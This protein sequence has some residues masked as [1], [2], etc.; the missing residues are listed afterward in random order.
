MSKIRLQEQAAPSTPA[1][2]KVFI[3]PKAGGEIYKKS[4]DGVEEQFLT[5][6][7][8]Q[9]IPTISLTGGQIAFPATAVP[10]TDPNT[11]DDYEE[12]AWTLGFSFGGGTTGITYS[13]QLG[14]YIKNSGIV[15]CTGAVTLT[16]KG[17]DNGNA[18]ITGL[19][20]TVFD[21]DANYSSAF[22]GYMF[23]IT[24]ADVPMFRVHRNSTIVNLYKT[25]NAGVTTNITDAAFANNS[26]LSGLGFIYLIV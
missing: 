19:P 3:Y 1:A 18:A 14:K 9:I 7:G 17:A 2:D 10:S 11:M 22:A 15:V 23:A 24:F 4:D 16:N 5:N 26:R 20:F 6:V 25:T 8:Q 13:L 21:S 12:G